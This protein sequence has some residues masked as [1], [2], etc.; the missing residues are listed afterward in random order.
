MEVT[1]QAG[2]LEGCINGF[3]SI[4][5]KKSIP[6]AVELVRVQ[7]TLGEYLDAWRVEDLNNAIKKFTKGKDTVPAKD[8]A[9]FMEAHADIFNKD[10]KV[11]VNPITV[12]Q[13]SEEGL[14]IEDETHV[15]LLLFTGLLVDGKS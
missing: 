13:L 4:E 12:E 6:L 11:K 1:I 15:A 5:G 2:L 8:H 10:I 3:A 14:Q 7:R 9:V